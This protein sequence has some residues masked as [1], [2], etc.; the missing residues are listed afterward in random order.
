MDRLIRCANKNAYTKE[1]DL[2]IQ[3]MLDMLMTV[4]KIMDRVTFFVYH[5]MKLARI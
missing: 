5:L 2:I 1:R 3:T 4:L